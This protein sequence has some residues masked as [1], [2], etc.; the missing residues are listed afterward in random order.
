M[1]EFSHP[2][3][4]VIGDGSACVPASRSKW[5]ARH[6]LI[7]LAA[8]LSAGLLA[9]PTAAA[10]DGRCAERATV[11]QVNDALELALD[12]AIEGTETVRLAGIEAPRPAEPG[13]RRPQA[14]PPARTLMDGA[15]RMVGN[16]VEQRTVCISAPSRGV[17]R[18]GRLLAHVY[19]DDGTWLQGLL[20]SRG[21]ARVRTTRD[22]PE[23]AREMLDLEREARDRR[24]GMWRFWE[25][26][27]RPAGEAGRFIG[28]FQ[29]VEGRV[30]A[31]AQR[32]N[33]WYLNFGEDWRSDFTVGI[34]QDVLSASEASAIDPRDLKGQQVR[35]RG[36]V[37][38][39]NG[40][41]IEID[42]PAQIE[43]LAPG[44]EPP[45]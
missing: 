26:R 15:L 16:A 10:S 38:K 17:D 5:S 22:A 11:V 27:V 29:V 6:A 7:G 36:W 32:R 37:E 35:V 4:P 43:R 42:H 41:M 19:L 14:K 1:R 20:L 33:H 28:S 31:V 39:Y 44:D 21:L 3:S 9:G 18:Y 30:L 13:D 24:L 12:R 40:P 45:G 25:F 8:A 34:P 23:L 2:S